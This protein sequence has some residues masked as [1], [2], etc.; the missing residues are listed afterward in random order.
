MP[1]IPD[2][3]KESDIK[4]FKIN[5]QST[6]MQLCPGA[7]ISDKETK[8]WASFDSSLSTLAS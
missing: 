1:K 4:I 8:L 6:R 2:R 3:R 5:L 7:L